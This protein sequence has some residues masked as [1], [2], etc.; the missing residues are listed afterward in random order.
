MSGQRPAR[1]PRP[2]LPAPGDRGGH[3]RA[4]VRGH[5]ARRQAG[6]RA[7]IRSGPPA[8]SPR[9]SACGT[10]SRWPTSRRRRWSTR[11]PNGWP[12]FGSTPRAPDQGRARVRG[13][14]QAVAEI[15]RLLADHPLREGLWLLLM[16]AL[17]GAG[18]H[19]EALEVYGR[20]RK[21]ISASWASTRAPSWPLPRRAAGQGQRRAA[22]HHLAAGQGTSS[23]EG[24][25]AGLSRRGRQRAVAAR[26]P[27]ARPGGAVRG[28]TP[29]SC[30]PT[31]PI[32]PAVRYR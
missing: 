5:G 10:A 22:G 28:R 21:A 17:D 8:S 12:S 13:H 4:A 11:R 1:H 31:S 27:A 32:S 26:A 20:A 6:V 18:R 14:A 23:R 19:A 9:R 29:R 15:R 24:Q 7:A 25:L 3:R 16:R 2:R 30:R